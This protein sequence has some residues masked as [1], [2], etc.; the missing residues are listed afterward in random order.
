[1]ANARAS[2]AAAL[3]PIAAIAVTSIVS[4]GQPVTLDGSGSAA[5]CGQSISTYAWTVT[6]G[7]CS[8]SAGADTA[9]PTVLAPVANTCNVRSTVTDDAGRLD[10]ANLTLRTTNFSR[11][12]AG[13]RTGRRLLCGH[14]DRVV[15]DQ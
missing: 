14:R 4:P 10:T 2:V 12:Q 1:M 8:I 6:S 7:T 15:V 13:E 5:A 11:P 3:R 9:T